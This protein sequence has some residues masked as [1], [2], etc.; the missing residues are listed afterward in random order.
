M[1]CAASGIDASWAERALDASGIVLIVADGDGTVHEMSAGAEAYFTEVVLERGSIFEMF[2]GM[3]KSDLREIANESIEPIRVAVLQNALNHA[4]S[5]S[6][7]GATVVPMGDGVRV[8]CTVN[9]VS[10]KQRALGEI[11]DI[12][13][14]AS[15]E[16]IWDWDI[17]TGRVWWSPQM[18]KVMGQDSTSLVGGVEERFQGTVHEHDF[19]RVNNA[20][21]AMLGDDNKEY[22]VEAR[23]ACGGGNYRWLLVRGK[24]LRDAE[25]NPIRVAG[26]VLDI[27]D[28]KEAEQALR[29]SEK[30]AR[31]LAN[32]LPQF[33]WEARPDGVVDVLNERFYEQTGASR[34]KVDNEG[35][36]SVMHPDDHQPLLDRW[37]RSLATGEDYEAESRFWNEKVKEYRWSLAQARAARDS[38]GKIVRWY[39]T[40][41]DIHDRKMA[42]LAL[43]ESEE[44]FRALAN[45][46]PVVIWV[47]DNSARLLFMNR[48][49]REFIGIE[50]EADHQAWIDGIHPSDTD[51]VMQ[52]IHDATGTGQGFSAEF[53]VRHAV[54]EHRWM[55]CTVAPRR[56]PA[57]DVIGLVGV[58]I[59]IDDRKAEEQRSQRLMSELD[60]R[61]KNNLGA[62]IYMA[63]RSLA[64]ADSLEAF[65]D[66]FKARLHAMARTHEALAR[67]RWTGVSLREVVRMAIEPYEPEGSAGVRISGPDVR[68]SAPKAGPMG[69]VLH[70]LASNAARHGALRDPQGALEIAWTIGDTGEMVLEWAERCPGADAGGLSGKPR[71]GNGLSLI[72]GL[73]KFD[74]RGWV[75]LDRSGIGGVRHR[76]GF[77]PDGDGTGRA[78]A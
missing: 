43:R 20:L 23:F 4:V 65:G 34:N 56:N 16:G 21:Q 35:W 39:G 31:E 71:N 54:L 28:R 44:R 12:V 41:T 33:V 57:G 22:R 19:T 61:V 49:G 10:A 37:Q 72:E 48:T 58:G 45:S 46:A 42:E 78:L 14:A 1:I 60:H 18:L 29:E 70:E 74:L 55:L 5:G 13:L 77:D 25:G 36:L 66:S 3:T 6:A 32:K 27:H 67:E 73:V 26:S 69:I 38:T 40:G 62:I 68:L 64:S 17:A 50:D 52:K 47:T 76:L 8:V 9:S 59:D 51:W 7:P 30:R 24:A 15:S 2:E 75:E 11:E 53:R 63:E